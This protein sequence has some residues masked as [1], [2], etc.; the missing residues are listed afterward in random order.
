VD[1]LDLLRYYHKDEDTDVILI[2]LEELRRGPE[3]I[4]A[5]K[6]I[7]SGDRPTPILVI[8]SGRTKRGAQAACSH[9]GAIAGSEGVY[10]AIFAQAGILRVDNISELFDFAKA[11]ASKTIDF[12]GKEVEKVMN[13]GRMAIVTN[14][15]GPGIVACDMSVTA[16]LTLAT[17]KQET[18]ETLLSHLPNTANVLVSISFALK[19]LMSSISSV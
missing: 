7:T 17:F 4:D 11:F 9:T 18:I 10:D 6:E 16:G 12:C 8:K 1:E 5:V 13:S 3:F 15:G 14:A 19:N 2:Y